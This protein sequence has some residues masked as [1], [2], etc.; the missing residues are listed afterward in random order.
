[1]GGCRDSGSSEIGNACPESGIE[2]SE[3]WTP[4]P[5]ESRQVVEGKHLVVFLV[6]GIR[7]ALSEGML[8]TTLRS[9][10]ASSP[11]T[12]TAARRIL[13]VDDQE[14]IL[15]LMAR[16]FRGRGFEVE[17]ARSVAE[18]EVALEAG[19]LDLIVADLGLSAGNPLEGFDLVDRARELCP[20]IRALVLTGIAGRDLEREA[21]ARGVAALLTKPQPL[22]ALDETICAVLAMEPG[23]AIDLEVAR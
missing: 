16:Y 13:F 15:R 7:L 20:G 10:A 9:P 11:R 18:A 6:A 2:P 21:E 1:M 14:M 4:Q 17:T 23:E 19:E 8:Q 22:A 12:R 5:V 3:S